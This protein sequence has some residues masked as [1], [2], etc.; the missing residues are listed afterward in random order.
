MNIEDVRAILETIEKE[1][2]YP[3]TRQL[4]E[5]LKVVMPLVEA[6]ISLHEFNEGINIAMSPAQEMEKA[7][8]FDDYIKAVEGL[9][10][11]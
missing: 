5:A 4:H 11:E 3:P 10:T 9:V 8:L 2:S 1:K 6:A 7:H